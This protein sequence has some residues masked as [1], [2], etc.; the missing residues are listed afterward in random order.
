MTVP[1]DSTSVGTV[2]SW[3]PSSC[4]ATGRL[5]FGSGA[6]DAVAFRVISAEPDLD[7][8]PVDLRRLVEQAMAKELSDRP[9]AAELARDC[10]ELLAAQTTAILFPAGQQPTLISD[11]VSLHRDL[12]PDDDP[13]WPAPTHRGSRTRPDRAQE[14]RR[15]RHEAL[16]SR[17]SLVAT[18]T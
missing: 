11:L 10:T 9:T 15:G 4:A 18:T 17:G 7:G 6:A 2:T 16:G 3:T 14:A 1:T 8:V 13:A 12:T 5:P